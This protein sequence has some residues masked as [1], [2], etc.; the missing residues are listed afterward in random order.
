MWTDYKKTFPVQYIKLGYFDEYI[1]QIVLEKK[2]ETILDI[3]GGVDGTLALKDT[4]S[5]VYLLDPYIPVKPEWIAGQVDWGTKKQFDLIVARG[6]INYLSTEELHKIKDMLVP[7]GIFIANTFI[8]CPSG[9]WSE[10][11]YLNVAGEKGIERSRYD[12]SEGSVKHELIPEHGDPI[13]H[14][15][16][17]YSPGDYEK[18]F[19]GIQIILHKANSGI[20]VFKK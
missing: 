12:E 15:F 19:P 13:T 3:G 9:V 8:K 6:S 11:P 18:I 7:G 1:R 5:Q 17:Y 4:G 10:R 16:F 2:P 20:L 14:S